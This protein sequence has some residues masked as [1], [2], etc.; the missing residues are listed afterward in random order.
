ML[1]A[2]L[3]VSSAFTNESASA[4]NLAFSSAVAA[5]TKACFAVSNAD[6]FSLTLFKAS[7]TWAGVAFSSLITVSAS[8]IASCA[9]VFASLYAFALSAVFP[10]V[11]SASV[12]KVLN[13]SF[14]FVNS[15]LSALFTNNSAAFVNSAFAAST[16]VCAAWASALDALFS[17]ANTVAASVL[18]ASNCAFSSSYFVL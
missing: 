11:G 2:V 7:V 5:S 18:A 1:S 10:V 14:A 13:S 16:F 17:F 8:W 3:P 9:A 15:V 12:A 4:F 6:F